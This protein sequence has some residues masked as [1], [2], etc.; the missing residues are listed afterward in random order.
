MR[1]FVVTTDSG[2]E[3]VCK[4]TD[5]SAREIA[6]NGCKVFALKEETHFNPIM[7]R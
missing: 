3:Y 7:D 2:E 4:M 6:N 1:K 5:S